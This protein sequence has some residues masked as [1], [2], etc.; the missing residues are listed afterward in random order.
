[1]LIAERQ[2]KIVDLVNERKSIRVTELSKLFSVTEETI[3]RDL[4][5]L[6]ADRKLSRSHGG[7]FS[8][9]RD[10]MELPYTE[11][12]GTNV[13]EKKEIANEA[14]KQVLEGDTVILDASTTAWYM[15][16]ALPNK[17]VTVLTNSIKV[18]MELSK[19]KEIT[20]I[21]TGGTLLPE[22]L[23]FVG[24]LAESA[25]DTYH[26]T[27][28]FISCKGL[29]FERGLSETDE[30]QARVKQ[31]MID[32]AE[33]TYIMIDYSKFGKQAF[34]RVSGLDDVQ[35][36]ITDSKVDEATIQQ[37]EDKSLHVIKVLEK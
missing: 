28:A 9:N 10:D 19:K 1:M 2:Q 4:E 14:V 29:H 7:A 13:K 17:R 8:M 26:V 21:S 3:R 37:L 33:M 30:Q 12:E 36:I 5:K 16:R 22:S 15:A 34:S 6:E 24:P 23:S 31:K 20:V 35:H 27:K 25:L 18:A 11:R 32:S